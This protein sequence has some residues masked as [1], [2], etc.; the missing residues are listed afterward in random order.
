M[1]PLRIGVLG[2]ARIAPAAIIQPVADT[3]AAEIVAVAARN[4]ARARAFADEHGIPVA[5]EGYETL[6]E[7]ASVEAVYIPLPNSEHAEWTIRALRAGK[8][9]LVEKPFANNTAEAER[10][11]AVALESGLVCMEAYH[12]RYHPMWA[13]ARA[14][15]PQIGTLRSAEARFD[16]HFEDQG[17]IR[18]DYALGGGAL[19]DLGCYPL[20]LLR[21][22]L[23]VEPTVSSA[24]YRAAADPLVDEELTARLRF[25]DVEATIGC[26]LM[27]DEEAMY[28]TFTGDLGTLMIDGFVKPQG[29]NSL[30][31]TLDGET[32]TTTASTE[33]TS[34]S[35]QLE[36]FVTAVRSGG[37]VVTGPEEAIATMQAIDAI[38]EAAGL[39]VRGSLA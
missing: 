21:T 3:P 27:T 5:Y 15:L 13:E 20:H 31:L 26:A 16:V 18:Y 39:P 37:P 12:Y 32:R 29:G 28:A 33:L 11:A 7:D 19:M 14:L 2:A 36:A 9:V 10:V 25:G 30:V 6:L 38:Y 4:N 8:H 17:N 1:Q 35:A 24:S 22:L 23:E 34:Y